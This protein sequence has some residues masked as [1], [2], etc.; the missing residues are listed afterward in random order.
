[1]ALINC[2]E[3]GKSISDRAPACPK[4]G[5]PVSGSNDHDSADISSVVT[6]KD[7]SKPQVQVSGKESTA[8]C[9][10]VIV[11]IVA[12]S[13]VIVLS[14]NG[15]STSDN[16]K[17]SSWAYT[18]CKSFVKKRLVS[19]STADFSF[20]NMVSSEVSKDTYVARSNVESQ[21]VFGAT[22][23]TNFSCRLRFNGGDASSKR[24]WTLESLTL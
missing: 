16:G 6:D 5:A 12:I 3:C 11:I 4:C 18:H 1:M 14:G 21:N 10:W 13:F 20:L 17:Y 2:Y 9:L 24:N 22:I 19:P 23:T 15:K 7:N 8:G